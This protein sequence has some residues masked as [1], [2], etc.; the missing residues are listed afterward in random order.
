MPINLVK[1]SANVLNLFNF[2]E[3]LLQK[4]IDD[5]MDGVFD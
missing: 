1:F 3:C 2:Y 5:Y 4:N